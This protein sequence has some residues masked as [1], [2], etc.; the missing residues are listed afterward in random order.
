M[1]VCII[2]GLFGNN[3]Q[4]FDMAEALRRYGHKVRLVQYANGSDVKVGNIGVGFLRPHGIFSK[5]HVA[6]NLMRVVAHSLFCRKDVV[7]CI[8]SSLLIIGAFYKLFFRSDLVYYSLEYQHYNRLKAW[9]VTRL[10]DRYIDVEHNRLQRVFS[11][12]GVHKSYMVLHNFPS[13]VHRALH[14]GL[15]R[16]YLREHYGLLGGEK[17]IVYAGSYQRYACI[18]NIVAASKSFPENYKLILMMAWGLPEQFDYDPKKCIFVPPQSGM[19][20]FDWLSDADCALLPYES[21]DDFNVLNC[22]PQKLFDCYLV[23]V[24]YVASSR[25]LICQVLD[26]FKGAGVL[27]DFTSVDSILKAIK[28][29]LVLKSPQCTDAMHKLYLA[30]YNYD[31]YAEDLS[32]FLCGDSV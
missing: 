5:F 26:Q 15:L 22:S 6:V 28:H 11:D 30:E 17:L 9:I 13:K 14:S 29:G 24:P 21:E 2:A 19:A 12:L 1:N 31:R 10:V 16:S 32:A 4:G 23:G 7:V 25:P 18:E 20:F 27:C 3:R 8:G